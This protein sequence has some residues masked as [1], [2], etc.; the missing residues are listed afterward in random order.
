VQR[1]FPAWVLGVLLFLAAR[2]LT[3]RI[4]S[5]SPPELGGWQRALLG[6]VDPH[7]MSVRELRQIPGIGPHLAGTL[8]SEREA[9]PES[10]SFWEEAPGI[11]PVRARGIEDWCHAH[12]V[13][14]PRG[15]PEPSSPG[16][17]GYPLAVSALARVACFAVAGFLAGCRE[18]ATPGPRSEPPPSPE[19]EASVRSLGLCAGSVH[20]LA[21]GPAA[22][23]TVLLLH[24]ARFSAQTWRELGTLESLARAGYRAIAVDWP[25]YGATPRWESEPE[26]AALLTKLCAELAVERVSLVAPSMSGRFAFEFVARHPERV[27]A[28]V[29]IAPAGADALPSDCKTP[30]LLLWGEQDEVIPVAQG[31]ALAAR[32]RSAR[33]EVFPGASHPCYLD[34]PARFHA[35]LLGF[36]R[37][38]APVP[39]GR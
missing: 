29:A 21:S 19:P 23:P 27:A 9:H 12:G 8:V 39:G 1:S 13:T 36:L 7:R 20:A 11:G 35:L 30:T 5:R 16:L 15:G 22:G 2:I 10:C 17:P 26:P 18:A 34:E 38:S 25:G 32:L 3:D 33:L 4:P 28:L 6:E 14:L 37:D 31:R 24:G